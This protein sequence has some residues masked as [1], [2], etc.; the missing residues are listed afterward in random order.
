MGENG[1]STLRRLGPSQ[2]GEPPN[3]GGFL[4]VLLYIK[5]S[6]EGDYPK[7]R[8]PTGTIHQP[9]SAHGGSV[10]AHGRQPLAHHCTRRGLPT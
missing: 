9:H 6:K 7:K 8:H 1:E 5:P 4:F 3:L 2:I 10:G